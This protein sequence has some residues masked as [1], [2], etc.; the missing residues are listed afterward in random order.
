MG[1]VS[2]ISNG[3]PG[4][5]T[6][7]AIADPKPKYGRRL[8]VIG[9]DIVLDTMVVSITDK[10]VDDAAFGFLS[11]PDEPTAK[12]PVRFLQKLAAYG[13]RYSG[14]CRDMLP[15]VRALHAE[16]S[17]L[18]DHVSKVVSVFFRRV[19]QVS[20]ILIML[21]SYDEARFARPL[22]SFTSASARFIIEFDACLWDVGPLLWYRIDRDFRSEVE[23]EASSVLASVCG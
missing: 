13:S 2:R 17:G 21:T 19:V 10:N 7:P 14:I 20:R 3:F 16:Y 9:Y 18:H 15:Y 5:D 4:S 8:P 6:H 12:I 23:H 22:A 11:L 1:H